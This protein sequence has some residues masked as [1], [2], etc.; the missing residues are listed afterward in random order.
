MILGVRGLIIVL[1]LTLMV[2]QKEFKVAFNAVI[3]NELIYLF[4]V[5]ALMILYVK[6]FTILRAKAFQIILFDLIVSS[7]FI[8]LF[9]ILKY[10][11]TF[12]NGWPIDVFYIITEWNVIAIILLIYFYF[13]E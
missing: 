7:V 11:L 2:F 1:F 5:K 12:F 4:L 3:L 8:S 13:N 6:T 10:G 9:L